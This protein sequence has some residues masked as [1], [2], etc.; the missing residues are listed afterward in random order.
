MINL[1]SLPIEPNGPGCKRRKVS[2]GNGVPNRQ[3]SFPDCAARPYG[4][5]PH[6]RFRVEGPLS[7]AL[8]RRG[9]TS[10]RSGSQARNFAGITMSDAC[11]VRARRK[12]MKPV[13]AWGWHLTAGYRPTQKLGPARRRCACIHRASNFGAILTT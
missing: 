2:I 7:G 10:G 9:R 5:P 1:F 3:S 6:L 8:S 13:K 11:A 4:M 12:R